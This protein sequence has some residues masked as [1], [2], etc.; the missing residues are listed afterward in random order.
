MSLLIDR[1]ANID[2]ADT[3]ATGLELPKVHYAQIAILTTSRSIMLIGIQEKIYK[4]V[5]VL[6]PSAIIFYSAATLKQKS[7]KNCSET[8]IYQQSEYG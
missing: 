3:V 4:L 1:G 5:S 7:L 2:E 8:C 6:V